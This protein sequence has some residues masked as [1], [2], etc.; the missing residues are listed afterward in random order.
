MQQPTIERTKDYDIFKNVK[1]NRAV[2][3]RHVE[4]M[5]AALIKENLLHLNPI[6]VNEKMEVIAGQHRLAAAKAL[7]LEV[8]YIKGQVSD[9]HIV[10]NNLNH[11][12]EDFG[13]VIKFFALKDANPDYIALHEFIELLEI[14][15]KAV[16]NLLFGSLS[17]ATI[18]F[19][20]S[21][22][23]KLPSNQEAVDK[24]IEN[25]SLFKDFVKEKRITPLAMFGSS[26][27]TVAFRNL[28]LLSEFSPVVW[29]NKLEQRWFELKPQLNS[30]EWTKQL[31]G[32]YNWKNHN[33]IQIDA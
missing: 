31:I 23:F 5:K 22:K 12:K 33:P 11:M 14:S 19:I 29:K 15:P 9:D 6:I 2:D 30:K 3:K 13:H 16:M 17:N 7:N 18:D 4:R 32:I 8:F 20:K 26:H 21:G 1:Y 25:F 27:F 28:V 24:L 10:D